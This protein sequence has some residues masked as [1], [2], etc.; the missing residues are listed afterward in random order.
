MK[1]IICMAF[2]IGLAIVGSSWDLRLSAETVNLTV[3]PNQTILNLAGNA[4][5][6]PYTAQVPGSLTA[7][8]SG[9]IAADLTNG[10]FT[11]SGGSSITA[12][13]NSLG[14]FDTTPNVVGVTSASYGVQGTGAVFPIGNATIQGV[15]KDLVFDIVAGTAQNG[16]AMSAGSFQLTSGS[17]IWGA[18]TDSGPFDGVSGLVGVTGPNTSATNVTWDGTTL[19]IPVSV[20][21]S[22]SNRVEVWT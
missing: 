21:T 11:F 12:D 10:V 22:G 3:L 4:F 16:S 14:P 20:Q 18:V 13:L 6:L 17:L 5:T 9:T 2:G 8:W 15:Y 1:R 7:N 19:T